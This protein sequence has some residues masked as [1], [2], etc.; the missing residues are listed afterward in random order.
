[1]IE[2]YRRCLDLDEDDL[3][4]RYNLAL[5]YERMKMPEEAEQQLRTGYTVSQQKRSNDFL[6]KFGKE[7]QRLGISIPG[8]E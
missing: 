3:N 4:A 6:T 1:V 5:I 8:G 7:M 2:P